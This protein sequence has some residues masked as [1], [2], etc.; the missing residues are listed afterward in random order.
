MVGTALV[1]AQ[2]TVSYRD[3]WA[4]LAV[5]AVAIVVLA[6]VIYFRRHH[7]RDLLM[8][9]VCFNIALFVIVR[10]L[11]SGGDPTTGLALGLGLFGALSIIRLRSREM[12]YTEVAYFFSTLAIALANG[13]G[14]GD[15]KYSIMLTA[16]VIVTMYVMDHLEPNRK[17]ERMTLVLD[18]VYANET[19]LRAELE[20]RIGARVIAVTINQIDYVRDITRLELEYVPRRAGTRREE[21]DLL[22]ELDEAVGVDR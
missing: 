17:V 15:V 14:V 12:S 19:A 13:V 11:A 9:F 8:A 10:V 18:E 20:R 6:Y 5:D 2:Q 4:Y 7:R 16:V 22:G 21:Q 1:A 3:F